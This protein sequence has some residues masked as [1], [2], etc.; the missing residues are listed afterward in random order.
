MLVEEA[1]SATVT[2]EGKHSEEPGNK[3][4]VNSFHIKNFKDFHLE[5]V[6]HVT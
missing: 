6:I 4:F 2:T 3:L 5:D 1:L